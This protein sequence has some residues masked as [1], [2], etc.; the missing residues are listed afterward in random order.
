MAYRFVLEV[1]RGPH[2]G[3]KR[4]IASVDDAEILN[5]GHY[6]TYDSK[7]AYAEITVASHSLDIIDK[8]YT[9]VETREGGSEDIYITTEHGDR[10]RLNAYNARTMRRAVQSD[11]DRYEGAVEQRGHIDDSGT[12]GALVADVPFGGR[13]TT[14]AAVAP[15]KTQIKLGNVDHIALRVRDLAKAEQFYQRFFGMDVMYRA[16]R[17]DGRWRFLDASFDWQESVATGVQPEMIRI[18][19]G[20]VAIVL[21]NVGYA[22]ILHENRVAYL[23]VQAPMDSLNEL[24]GKAL[25]ASFTV[26]EDTPQSFRF[27][28]PFGMVWQIIAE[29][30]E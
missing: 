18:E 25:F 5:E 17:Q 11:Q 28:D 21:T 10:F 29:T 30:Q 13:L 27:V 19:N 8:L 1:P 3:A 12:G 6:N 16:Y 22:K 24:R 20:P 15:A 9:W 23:S 4:V 7:Q 26:Q 2:D 14:G